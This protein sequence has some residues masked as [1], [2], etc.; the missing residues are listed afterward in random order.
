MLNPH[1]PRIFLHEYD[2][3]GAPH[4]AG[5]VGRAVSA[6]NASA[7]PG[8]TGAW[9]TRRIPVRNTAGHGNT[10]GRHEREHR[11]RRNGGKATGR[12]PRPPIWQATGG[13]GKKTWGA[14]PGA[15]GICGT[16]FEGPKFPL[17]TFTCFYLND[18]NMA[19][20]AGNISGGASDS[21]SRNIGMGREV[22]KNQRRVNQTR[23]GSILMSTGGSYSGGR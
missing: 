3:A 14:A 17:R 7:P 19:T 23:D 4:P 21:Y 10:G 20:A 9:P 2:D 22:R 18:S 16:R 1:H 15:V 11:I 12:W 13:R 6:G 8:G 5:A